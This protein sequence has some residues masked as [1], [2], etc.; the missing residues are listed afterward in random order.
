MTDR[1]W[2]GHGPDSLTDERWE[3]V[4]GALRSAFDREV[5]ADVFTATRS[6]RV[7][8][9]RLR[10]AAINLVDAAENVKDVAR[11]MARRN[12][13]NEETPERQAAR[14]RY[15]AALERLNAAAR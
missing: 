9:E 11:R 14:I 15:T 8:M 12:P 3:V 4:E 6:L 1:E 2:D 13:T 5:E 10:E 7:E